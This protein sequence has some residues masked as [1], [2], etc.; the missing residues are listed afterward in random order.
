LSTNAI[1]NKERQKRHQML[2]S[3]Q[4]QDKI[5]EIAKKRLENTCVSDSKDAD[6]E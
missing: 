3:L 5:K 6:S 4:I 2:L 1:G